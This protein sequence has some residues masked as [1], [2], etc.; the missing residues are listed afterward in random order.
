MRWL[1]GGG[2]QEGSCVHMVPVREIFD[3]E[4]RDTRD[5]I[6]VVIV[7]H[8]KYKVRPLINGNINWFGEKCKRH[9]RV[10]TR[11]R[12]LGY[13]GTEPQSST[14]LFAQLIL[15]INRSCKMLIWFLLTSVL[16]SLIA[17]HLINEQLLAIPTKT[18]SCCDP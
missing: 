8:L 12:S 17:R 9:V 4:V 6:G 16:S 3:E 15:S 5:P 11:L 2:R 13:S 10:E 1:D 7:T 18:V 14:L